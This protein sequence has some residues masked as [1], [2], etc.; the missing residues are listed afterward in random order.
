M[1]TITIVVGTR[2]FPTHAALQLNEGGSTTYY[3]FGPAMQSPIWHG[4]YDVTPPLPKGT[5]PVGYSGNP[6]REFEFVDSNHY[7]VNSYTIEVPQGM[8]EGIRDRLAAASLD[9]QSRY[10][11][12]NFFTDRICTDYVLH[13]VQAAMPGS[14]LSYLSRLPSILDRQ[15]ADIAASGDGKYHV[16]LSP[17]DGNGALEIDTGLAGLSRDADPPQFAA[18]SERVVPWQEPIVRDSARTAGVPSRYN[19]FEYGYPDPNAPSLR[20]A[21]SSAPAFEPDAVYSPDGNFIGNFP[22]VASTPERRSY[23]NAPAATDGKLAR[24]NQAN[25]TIGFA[26]YGAFP[27]VPVS[28]YIPSNYAPNVLD[29]SVPVRG[30]PPA[31]DL[32][33]GAFRLGRQVPPGGLL[34]LL[35]SVSW[36]DPSDPVLPTPSQEN[37]PERRLIGRLVWP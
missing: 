12:Y 27:S 34:G 8:V 20:P 25:A 18:P 13:L 24:T 16:P 31:N 33:R 15:L 10:P 36:T 11:N 26:D 3:G 9:Y 1:A 19:V 21:P 28:A 5:S 4:Q 14:D 17:P 6:R 22:S 2:G 7:K 23:L 32:V 29:T 35:D 37:V 30:G